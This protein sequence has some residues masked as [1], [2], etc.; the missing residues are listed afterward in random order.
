M[1][2][3]VPAHRTGDI[4]FYQGGSG[5]IASVSAKAEINIPKPTSTTVIKIDSNSVPR[6]WASI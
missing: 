2:F 6:W 4:W 1:M 3:F 5:W